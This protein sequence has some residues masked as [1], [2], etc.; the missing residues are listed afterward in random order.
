V[1]GN[2][3][4]VETYFAS[5]DDILK[6]KESSGRKKDLEDIGWIRKYGKK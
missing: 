1:K 2:Y 6:N 5:I 4:G 3:L